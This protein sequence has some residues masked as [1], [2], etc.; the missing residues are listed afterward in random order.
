MDWLQTIG[1]DIL[2]K[3]DQKEIKRHLLAMKCDPEKIDGFIW[4][5]D[6]TELFQMKYG[7]LPNYEGDLKQAVYQV[8]TKTKGSHLLTRIDIE[9]LLK[10]IKQVVFYLNHFH[11]LSDRDQDFYLDS[12]HRDIA[13]S[14]I[15]HNLGGETGDK[16]KAVYP[17]L[18]DLQL[19]L[20]EAIRLS[21]FTKRGRT[22][23][24]YRTNFAYH[25][26]HL[27]YMYFKKLPL[28]TTKNSHFE[29]IVSVCYRVM[30]IETP[31]GTDLS[32]TISKAVTQYKKQLG[33]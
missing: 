15:F 5:L 18:V 22:P 32:K 23:K 3:E 30:N 1:K 11:L 19:M 20:K 26:I 13:E 16:L 27:F 21:T 14:L 33:Q 28:K 29:Q 9:D 12:I 17:L 7:T 2:S 6:R 25:I 10:A 31:N 24:E 8:N 4:S